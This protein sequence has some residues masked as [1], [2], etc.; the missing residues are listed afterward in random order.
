MSLFF[1]RALG[2]AVRVKLSHTFSTMQTAQTTALRLQQQ[3]ADQNIRYGAQYC[4][5][6]GTTFCRLVTFK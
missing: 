6:F 5:L 3:K 1:M 2:I 4:N